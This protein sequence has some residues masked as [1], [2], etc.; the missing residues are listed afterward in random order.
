M[1]DIRSTLL[2]IDT[3]SKIL[4]VFMGLGICL[5]VLKVIEL[6]MILSK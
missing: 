6:G 1:K 5:F 4:K 3:A 2:F